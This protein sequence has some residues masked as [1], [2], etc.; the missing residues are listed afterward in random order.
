MLQP[1][2][3]SDA[4]SPRVPLGVLR[5]VVRAAVWAPGPGGVPSASLPSPFPLFVLGET[6]LIWFGGSYDGR[7][8][9]LN[10]KAVRLKAW[11]AAPV[12]GF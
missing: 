10:F 12:G 7:I 2:A 3:R 4:Q 5:P 1:V 11:E 8:E 9:V 6:F